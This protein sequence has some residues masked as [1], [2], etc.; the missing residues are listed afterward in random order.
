MNW[1]KDHRNNGQLH[2]NL[3]LVTVL[4]TVNEN[5]VERNLPANLNNEK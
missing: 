5:V 2:N 1:K 4:S 3:V